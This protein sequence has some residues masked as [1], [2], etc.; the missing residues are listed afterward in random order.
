MSYQVGKIELHV[1]E[2]DLTITI[3]IAIQILFIIHHCI[4]IATLCLCMYTLHVCV[5]DHTSNEYH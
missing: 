2:A 4:L 3:T 1:F 5:C